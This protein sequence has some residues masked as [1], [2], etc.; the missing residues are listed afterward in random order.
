[1]TV[2]FSSKRPLTD[3]EEAEIQRMIASDPDNPELTDEQIAQAKPFREAFPD[4]A[5]AIDRELARRGRPPVENPRRQ[6]SIRLDPE[7]L[8][9]YKSTGKGWQSRIN[10][11]LRKAAGL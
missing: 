4:L 7:V 11:A 2:R 10:D 5:A 9:H 8:E 6:V 3:E 1:M